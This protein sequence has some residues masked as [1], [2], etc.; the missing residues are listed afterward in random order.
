MHGAAAIPDRLTKEMPNGKPWE[1]PFNN[2][3]LNITRDNLPNVFTLDDLI[4][5]TLCITEQAIL[6]EGG[7]K[8]QR[9][10]RT[11]YVVPCQF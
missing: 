1:T 6:E 5:R 3:Y 8:E 10:G 9:E 2:R 11:I 7:R 4:D